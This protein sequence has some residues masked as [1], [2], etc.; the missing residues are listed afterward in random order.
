MFGSGYLCP[1]MSVAVKTMRKGEVAELAMKFSCKLIES[2]T[3]FQMK[4][5]CIAIILLLHFVSI[6]LLI[7]R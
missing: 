4:Y 1:A 3:L 6:V 7:S 2:H 5:A